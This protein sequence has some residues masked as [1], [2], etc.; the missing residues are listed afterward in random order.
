MHLDTC[1]SYI[2]LDFMSSNLSSLF[3]ITTSI[4][5]IFILFI[6]FLSLFFSNLYFFFFYFFNFL[7]FYFF[8][9]IYH[10]F[11]KKF[12]NR[13]NYLMIHASEVYYIES[14]GVSH[15]L[16]IRSTLET[17]LTILQTVCNGH[18]FYHFFLFVFT[19]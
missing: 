17:R 13:F 3:I 8:N 19:K 4:P 2:I 1:A 6:I 11:L 5:V 16:K 18:F 9:G 7:F 10:D 15:S 12:G 14:N